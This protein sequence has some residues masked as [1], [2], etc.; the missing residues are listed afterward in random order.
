MAEE[1]PTPRR[2]TPE[3]IARRKAEQE[4]RRR[5][6]EA[7]KA[8]GGT[9]AAVAGAALSAEEIER[10]RAEAEARRT[11]REGATAP[12]MPPEPVAAPAPA[13]PAQPGAAAAPAPGGAPA[14]VTRPAPTAPAIRPAPRAAPAESAA[15]PT[16]AAPGM[17]RREF[18]YYIWGASMALLT[19]EAAGAVLWFAMPRFRAGEFGGTFTVDV[20]RLPQPDSGPVPYNEGKFWLVNIGPQAAQKKQARGTSPQGTKPGVV[21][22]YK[23]CTHL[24]CLYKWVDLNN[25]FECPCHGSKFNVNGTWIEGPAPRNLDRFVVRAV[26]ANG[27]VLAETPIGDPDAATGGPVP[28][29]P[30]EIPPGTVQL[31]VDTGK[32][33]KGA[34]HA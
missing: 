2:L 23:V 34:S 9:S 29:D 32:R 22:L 5:A 15:P 7:A 10:R 20:A 16:T 14:I 26:D 4:E 17:T 27:N 8:G 18:L 19:A 33:V 30:I 12:A 1:T 24:G 11:P 21:A 6:R 28:G 31:I 13:E 3:E 25:R